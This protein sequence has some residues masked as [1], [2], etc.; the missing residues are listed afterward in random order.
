MKVFVGYASTQGQSSKIARWI[1]DGLV[2]KGHGVELLSLD[3]SDDLALDRFD[4]AVIVGSIHVG[5]YK[6]S[7]VQFMTDHQRWLDHHPVLF[8]SVSLAAAG[9]DA[10][11]WRA[12]DRIIEDLREVTGW[13][14]GQVAQIAGAYK[15]SEYDIFT[16]FIMRRIEAKKDPEADLNADREYTDWTA[17]EALVTGWM[18]T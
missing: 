18:G 7:L 12:I 15:P 14:T 2:A 13:E 17:L 3:D 8:A 6:P 9:H 16:R 5:H 4:R 1:T 11:D 10:E